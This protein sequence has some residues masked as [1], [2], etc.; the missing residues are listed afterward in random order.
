MGPVFREALFFLDKQAFL[1]PTT[2]KP[3]IRELVKEGTPVIGYIYKDDN[4]TL[5]ASFVLGTGIV[6]V[7]AVRNV[8]S[9]IAEK[10]RC[11]WVINILPEHVAV[12]AWFVDLL[13]PV[14][15]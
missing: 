8:S 3:A 4:F 2:A 15:L 10:A 14:V 11:D 1:M 12:A 7:E 6:A 13:E 5:E 9:N